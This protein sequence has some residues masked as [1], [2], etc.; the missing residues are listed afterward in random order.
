MAGRVVRRFAGEVVPQH[1]R[2]RAV[3]NTWVSTWTV[4][5]LS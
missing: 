4:K 1:V 3:M 5:S 2:E